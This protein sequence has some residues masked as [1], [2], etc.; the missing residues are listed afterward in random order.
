MCQNEMDLYKPGAFIN[1]V[2]AN[3]R[4]TLQRSN[5]TGVTL[6]FQTVLFCHRRLCAAA[7]HDQTSLGLFVLVR[8]KK[9]IIV[10]VKGKVKR[11]FDMERTFAHR[12]LCVSL[13]NPASDCD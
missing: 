5:Q 10:F 2:F 4:K 13:E 7:L 6:T 8:K 12:N 3:E 9:L 1:I 11:Q